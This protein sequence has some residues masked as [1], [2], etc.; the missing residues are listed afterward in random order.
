MVPIA[1]S[2][3]PVLSA[4]LI[5]YLAVPSN[6][7]VQPTAELAGSQ[8]IAAESEDVRQPAAADA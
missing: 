4:F 3:V 8:P 2:E 1:P 7:G 6:N 5:S